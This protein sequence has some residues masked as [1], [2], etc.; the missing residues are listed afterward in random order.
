MINLGRRVPMAVWRL[1][2][3]LAFLGVV[4]WVGSY[5]FVTINRLSIFYY[6]LGG[7]GIFLVWLSHT[8][9]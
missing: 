7:I 8:K 3:T 9:R 4:V 6:L 5:L 1:L 2:P